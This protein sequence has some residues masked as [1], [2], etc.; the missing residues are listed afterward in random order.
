MLYIL[1]FVN[2]RTTSLTLYENSWYKKILVSSHMPFCMTIFVSFRS[3]WSCLSDHSKVSR[4][5]I[6]YE[7]CLFG[8]KYAP[9]LMASFIHCRTSLGGAY[10]GDIA[11]ADSLEA[12]GAGHDDPMSV[13][14][15][16]WPKLSDFS[17]LMLICC[18]C[19][20]QVF[21]YTRLW[22]FSKSWIRI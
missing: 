8:T 11:F 19:W 5:S 13:A 17:F 18:L 14:I 10:D 21:T 16:G 4:L 9:S 22:F 7:A 15:G 6:G 12:F 2:K 1:I 20:V 3:R